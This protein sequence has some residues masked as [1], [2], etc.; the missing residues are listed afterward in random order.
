MRT[1]F[2]TYMDAIH[3]KKADKRRL[4]VEDSHVEKESEFYT[5]FEEGD[6][7]ESVLKER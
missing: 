7:V 3:F 6:T 2:R 4:N 1:V 5:S